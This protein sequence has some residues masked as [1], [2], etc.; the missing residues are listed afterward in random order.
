MTE[1]DNEDRELD[2]MAE[3]YEMLD[4]IDEMYR[5]YRGRG[6][7]WN[8]FRGNTVSNIV[9]SY[10][11]RHLPDDVKILKLAYVEGC[12]T[13]FDIMIVNED[14][15]PLDP[16]DAYQNGDIKLIL[17]IKGAG[18]FYRRDEVKKRMSEMLQK[19]RREVGK[20]MVY[21]S[22]WEAKAH[23]N[24]VRD[25]LGNDTAFILKVEGESEPE[26]GEWQRF[27]ER[28]MAILKSDS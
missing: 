8:R 20:P 5:K 19:C 14:A 21:L 16:T 11:Q 23:V 7:R 1:A 28:V 26:Y 27:L 15:K 24:E 3:Q 6:M 4:Q 25:A 18:V 22:A 9:A 12:P 17:E 2:L 10:L 13:E